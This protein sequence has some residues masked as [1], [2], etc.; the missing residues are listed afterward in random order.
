MSLDASKAPL[1][2]IA[3]DAVRAFDLDPAAAVPW[4]RLLQKCEAAGQLVRQQ[5]GR[6][7]WCYV[8]CDL[9]DVVTIRLGDLHG[10]LETGKISG[11]PIMFVVACVGADRPWPF[12]SLRRRERQSKC[13]L[14][15]FERADGRLVTRVL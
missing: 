13:R 6:A 1:G 8:E 9:D 10:F 11:G 2:E 3:L 4:L 14:V 5:G 12:N 7:W 15:A